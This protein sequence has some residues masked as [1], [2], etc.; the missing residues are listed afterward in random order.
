MELNFER[1]LR[2]SILNS[3]LTSPHRELE[4]VAETHKECRVLD[5]LFYAHLAVWYHQ[6]GDVRDH[7]E[8]FVASLL[9]ADLSEHRE[10]G[11]VLL[12]TLPP[13]QVARVIDFLKSKLGKVPRS[14]RTAVELYLRKR[15][16]N[17]EHFDRAALRGRKAM[18]QLY[19][20]LHIR[21]SARADAILFRDAPPES[22]LAHWVK[23]LAAAVTP[24][25]QARLIVVKVGGSSTHLE[26]QM[27]AATIEFQTFGFDGD[28]YSLPNLIPLLTRPSR[29]DLLMEIL[30]TPLP[31]RNDLTHPVCA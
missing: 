20:S 9:A 23:Q 25:E 11:F 21:P 18:K 6:Y 30:E 27:K 4:R 26:R 12:Q 1:D 15:E 16:K 22:S 2:L 14:A 24:A 31:K 13:Y 3:L 7:Q 10:A 8:V 29:L 19:A 17:P 5:P 28:Y